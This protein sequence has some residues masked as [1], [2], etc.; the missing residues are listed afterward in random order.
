ML[1]HLIL[2]VTPAFLLAQNPKLI[3]PGGWGKAKWGMSPDQVLG[4]L[5]G[6]RLLTGNPLARKFGNRV[7][8]IGVDG[9]EIASHRFDA[10]MLFDDQG[11]ESVLLK[12][13]SGEVQSLLFESIEDRLIAKYGQPAS[14]DI[15]TVIA[16]QRRSRW[17]FPTTMVD[18]EVIELD[19]HMAFL[20]IAYK[21]R[22][23]PGA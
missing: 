11:L 18:L 4:A 20:V 9:I 17:L 6:A 21:K 12:P 2:A 13:R 23:A 3:D 5:P 8:P 7:S 10:F 19:R 22:D 1:C 14:R 15:Q 16:G